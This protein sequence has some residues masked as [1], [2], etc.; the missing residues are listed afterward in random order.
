MKRWR[1]TALCV[2]LSFMCLF[3][4]VGYAAISG[5]L[6]IQ[7]TVDLQ[8]PNALYITSV[9]VGESTEGSTA[10]VNNFAGTVV[11]LSVSL[12]ASPGAT[13]TVVVT[14][15]NN[16]KDYYAFRSVKYN[17]GDYTY[18]NPRIVFENPVVDYDGEDT[19]VHPGKS[20]T[21]TL[22]FLHGNYLNVPENLNAILNFYFGLS[23]MDDVGTQYDSY[24]A[25]FLTNTNKCGLND[26]ASGGKGDVIVGELKEV[27]AL[28]DGDNLS[29]ANLKKVSNAVNTA[30]TERLTFVY[31]Y[32]DET[33]INLYMYE[34]KYNDNDS[35]QEFVPVY[36]VTISRQATGNDAYT[37]WRSE[38]PTLGEAQIV[39]RVNQKYTHAI[40]PGTW[41]V[42]LR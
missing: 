41:R 21:I 3:L 1:K 8:A 30:G 39:P 11:N 28:Y 5:D 17:E 7:G 33:N 4:C 12:G 36:K 19:T 15:Y 22:T 20:A 37:E 23:G 26:T 10:A 24:I 9:V 27:G 29:G 25:L 40:N 42:T 13:Q 35:N 34:E 31:Q 16:T 6:T 18:D 38:V 32:V 2:V 14:V